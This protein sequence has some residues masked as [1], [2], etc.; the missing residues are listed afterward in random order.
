MGKQQ[1][2]PTVQGLRA[3]PVA[4]P[5]EEDLRPADHIIVHHMLQARAGSDQNGV[6]PCGG[7]YCDDVDVCQRREIAASRRLAGLLELQPRHAR[8]ELAS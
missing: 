3:Y 7:N 1:T 5:D 4:E 6:Q 8:P 2:V